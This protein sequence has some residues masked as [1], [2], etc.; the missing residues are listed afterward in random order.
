MVGEWIQLC[1][2]I[3]LRAGAVARLYTGTLNVVKSG[4]SPPSSVSAAAAPTTFTLPSPRGFASG[5]N[6]GCLAPACCC[7]RGAAPE[8]CHPQENMA[9]EDGRRVVWSRPTSSMS[10]QVR[11]VRSSSPCHSCSLEVSILAMARLATAVAAVA[12]LAREAEA[13]INADTIT[14]AVRSS[15][16]G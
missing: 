8:Y 11:S 5:C 4:A 14:F 3:I 13:G 1:S 16:L 12:L 10:C 2:K 7:R 15:P 9:C 6:A